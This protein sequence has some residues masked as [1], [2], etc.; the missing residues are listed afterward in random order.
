ML[1]RLTR[2]QV[3]KLALTLEIAVRGKVAQRDL[4][5]SLTRLQRRDDHEQAAEDPHDRLVQKA[6]EAELVPPAR[7]R[8]AA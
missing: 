1:D 5:S 4:A 7:K 3:D 6:N 2:E 8:R